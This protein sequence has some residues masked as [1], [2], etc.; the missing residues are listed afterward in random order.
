MFISTVL[1]RQSF[2]QKD[3]TWLRK[4]VILCV[5]PRRELSLLPV[6]LKRNWSAFMKDYVLH[7]T[8]TIYLKS[9]A[10]HPDCDCCTLFQGNLSN[11]K[12][13]D[14]T[15]ILLC[16]LQHVEVGWFT[17]KYL[18]VDHLSINVHYYDGATLYFSMKFPTVAP[19]K[20]WTRHFSIFQQIF[21]Y[22][23]VP[24]SL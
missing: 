8:T 13:S 19:K 4:N 7:V 24:N 23:G 10:Y 6:I 17:R 15:A 1:N 18:N 5:T 14:D 22:S 9:S 3:C 2:G 12:S 20:T 16:H 11:P 21:G